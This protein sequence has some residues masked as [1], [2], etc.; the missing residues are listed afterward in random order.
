MRIRFLAEIFFLTIACFYASQS[1]QAQR[2]GIGTQL[3]D[4]SAIL[5]VQSINAGF[6]PP[7]MTMSQRNAIS[8]PAPG[9]MIYCTDCG[10]NETGEMNYYNGK[11]WASMNMANT[12][13]NITSL[14]N[15][16]IG[17]QVWNSKN[18]DV[19]R[20]RNGDPIPQV[21]DSAQWRNL[22]TGAWCWYKN[23]SATYAAKYGRLYNWYAVNDPRGIAPQ[24]WH[25]PTKS[26]FNTLI[27]QLDAGADTT[28]TNSFSNTAGLAL[29]NTTGWTNFPDSVCPT[30]V[31]GDNSSGF[32]AMPG[33]VSR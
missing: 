22:T 28:S 3:P 16:S 20:Y 9:L 10:N 7:R 8:N 19:V 4:T 6:L 26:E 15:T 18:L 33:G 11:V 32:S 1:I 2:I 12:N 25:V 27:K 17:T 5:E 21:T 24:G 30:C 31:N 14:P 23:D 13:S 29:K